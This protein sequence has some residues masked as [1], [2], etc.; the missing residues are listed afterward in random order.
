MT[1]RQ[2]A[3]FVPHGGGPCFFMDWDP[4]DTWD[5]QRRF[6]EDLPAT[7]R[8]RP[9]ALLV[10]S[11]HWEAP[12]FTVQTNP[13]PPLLFDYNGFPP[14]TYKLTWPAPGD[15][16]LAGRV[17]QLLGDA[18]FET[19]AD[20]ARGYDHGVFVPLKVAF[21]AADIPTVQLSLRAD[22]D[23][24][25]HLAAGRA[26]A[27]LRDAG[28]LIVGSGNTYHNMAVMMRAM[29][30]GTQGPA[31]GTDFDRWLTDAAT[32][33]D[34]VRR[35]AMLAAWSQARGQPA[36][37][38]PDPVACGRRRRLGGSRRQDAGGSCHGR[39]RKRFPV[40]LTG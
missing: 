23:P 36:R 28:V 8:A 35:D 18:G 38:T 10:I 9:N 20:P 11:G 16:A 39:G 17:R 26:L 21:P 12:V 40:W 34:P 31:A 15:P 14:H 1:D 25:A 7:L 19:A 32:Q 37:G 4:P 27:P 22:L 2:P 30:G 3:V 5:R 6:L 13:M 33:D 24:Q 29:R